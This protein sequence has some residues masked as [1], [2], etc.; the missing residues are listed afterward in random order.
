[1]KEKNSTIISHIGVLLVRFQQ[2]EEKRCKLRIHPFY[3][4][5]APQQ[6]IKVYINGYFVTREV[7]TPSWQEHTFLLPQRYVRTGMNKLYF[8]YRYA[9]S[10]DDVLG[11]PDGRRLSVAFDSLECISV[12][13]EN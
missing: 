9:Q 1:M 7:L 11:T 2:S 13:H 4:P 3:Y 8:E 10:P 6:F 12:P 5:G